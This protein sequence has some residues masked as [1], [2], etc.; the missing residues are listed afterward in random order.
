MGVATLDSSYFVHHVAR[1]KAM[2]FA[3]PYSGDVKHVRTHVHLIH[4][5]FPR[6]T[7]LGLLAGYGRC[8][9]IALD[10]MRGHDT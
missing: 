6:N 3:W 4:V 5:G 8:I 10:G 2:A 1:K 7:S 9:A